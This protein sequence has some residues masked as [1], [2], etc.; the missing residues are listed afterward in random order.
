ML[1]PADIEDKAE[2]GNKGEKRRYAQ[3]AWFGSS[4]GIFALISSISSAETFA[5][6]SYIIIRLWHSDH[7]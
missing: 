5:F 2:I 4:L 7:K 3:T 1:T 6:E